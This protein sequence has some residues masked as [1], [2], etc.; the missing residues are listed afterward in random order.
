MDRTRHAN[1]PNPMRLMHWP[2][3]LQLNDGDGG[4]YCVTCLSA[5]RRPLYPSMRHSLL[6]VY[7]PQVVF[8]EKEE[9]LEKWTVTVSFIVCSPYDKRCV[10]LLVCVA[11]HGASR[12]PPHASVLNDV[13]AC[14][15]V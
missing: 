13:C 2:L 9:L 8:S 6:S 10:S 5:A 1:V 15:C 11:S 4:S 3:L 7:V 12:I 14:L